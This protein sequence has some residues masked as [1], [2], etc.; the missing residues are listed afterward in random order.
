MVLAEKGAVGYVVESLGR[1]AHSRVLDEK[2]DHL[3]AVHLLAVVVGVHGV[4]VAICNEAFSRLADDVGAEGHIVA[5]PP[6]VA[7]D[8]IVGTEDDAADEVLVL[9]LHG[10]ECRGF[11][12]LL[13]E[14]LEIALDGGILHQRDAQHPV[15]I[16]EGDA[17]KRKSVVG[18]HILQSAFYLEMSRTPSPLYFPHSGP[19]EPR[20]TALRVVTPSGLFISQNRPFSYQLVSCTLTRWER[21]AASTSE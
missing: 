14:H 8:G 7:V 9:V 1:N 19:N 3:H 15:I 20:K 21:A 12:L 10:I 17:V 5:A 11:R 16:G 4:G 18:S 13:A 6:V 2:L